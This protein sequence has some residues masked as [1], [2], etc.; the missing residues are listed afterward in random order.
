MT[1]KQATDITGF[2]DAIGDK[3]LALFFMEW[4]KNGQNATK[5]YLTLHPSVDYH[6]ARVLGSRQLAK[7]N[8]SVILNAHNLGIE[9]YIRQLKEGL[10]AKML[11]S[12]SKA[13]PDH[14]TR[15]L[16]HKALGELLGFEGK[17]TKINFQ[18]NQYNFA[19]L[20]RDIERDRIARGLPK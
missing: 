7:V 12:S 14:K 13:V 16:Y 8:I 15:R 5:A 6:S 11:A 17:E 1:D 18:N 10:S 9:T 19:N 20:G 3:T 2:E 4:L